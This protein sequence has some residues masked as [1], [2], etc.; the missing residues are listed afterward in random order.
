M[1]LFVSVLWKL[2][3][4]WVAEMRADFVRFCH[5]V[6]NNVILTKIV[7]HQ[8]ILRACTT[9]SMWDLIMKKSFYNFG[10]FAS[11]NKT[12]ESEA[13]GDVQ[14]FPLEAVLVCWL[15][16]NL[17]KP[18]WKSAACFCAFI[19]CLVRH[20]LSRKDSIQAM[21]ISKW[22][23]SQLH[24]GSSCL[25]SDRCNTTLL[26]KKDEKTCHSERPQ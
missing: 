9:W 15:S 26:W 18:V 23:C 20:M 16:C 2:P 7:H 5:N 22:S 25:M 1:L 12:L 24:M 10:S 17:K 6:L 4:Y 13:M 8:V 11:H 21:H 3:H 19:R 14:L